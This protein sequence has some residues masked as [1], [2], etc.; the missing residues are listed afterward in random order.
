M[1]LGEIRMMPI[2][3]PNPI[4]TLESANGVNAR[5]SLKADQ[6]RLSRG[7]IPLLALFSARIHISQHR[8][9]NGMMINAVMPA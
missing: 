9:E 2:R 6:N 4:I 1:R 7:L 5:F 3:T 8:M